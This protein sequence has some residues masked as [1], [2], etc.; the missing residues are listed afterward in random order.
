MKLPLNP[1]A[2]GHTPVQQAE[3]AEGYDLSEWFVPQGP[4][5]IDLD[6][7][8]RGDQITVNGEIRVETVTP[9]SRCAAPVTGSLSASLLVF[10][11][12]RGSDSA[13]DEAALAEE[14]S[15]LYHD[16]IE[17]DLGEA[18]REAVILEVPQTTLC[19]PD[20]RGLCPN[21]GQDLNESECAC[22]AG[23]T[24]PRWEALKEIRN[25]ND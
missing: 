21:C 20:C 11:D 5:R 7:E 3:P 24:D 8:R 12:R 22:A 18:I 23:P 17:L 25:T 1:L 19:R 10:A 16:G 6:A 9:C 2:Q 14:G 15:V 13:R 4:L